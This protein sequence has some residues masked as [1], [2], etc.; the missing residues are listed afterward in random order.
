M[1][2]RN[3]REVMQSLR[4]QTEWVNSKTKQKQAPM[5]GFFHSPLLFVKLRILTAAV[6]SSASTFGDK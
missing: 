4:T 3:L 6:L 5:R 2:K 1:V